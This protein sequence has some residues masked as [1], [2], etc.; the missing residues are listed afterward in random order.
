MKWY[1]L[2]APML[3]VATDA[4][5]RPVIN[6]LFRAGNLGATDEWMEIVLTEDMTAAELEAYFVGDSTAATDAKFSAYQF[7]AMAGIASEFRAGTII[8]IAG[9]TGGVADVAYDPYA[10]DWNILLTTGSPNLAVVTGGGD[11]AGTD[12]AWVDIASAGATL[13]A[14][15]F[16][17]NWDAT[18]GVFGAIASVTLAP[19][20]NNT[21]LQLVGATADATVPGNWA[22]S[23]APGSL[24][25]GLPNGG[26]NTIDIDALRAIDRDGD[27][28]GISEGDCDDDNDQLFPIAWYPDLDGDGV[29]EDDPRVIADS[30]AEFSANQGDSGWTYGSYPAFSPLLFTALPQFDNGAHHAAQSFSTPFVS[31]TSAHP[32]VDDFQWAV[33]RWTSDETATATVEL[34]AIDV[35]PFC[36]DGANVRL[37]RN[38]TEVW[39]AAVGVGG[40]VGPL[41]VPLDVGMGDTIDLIVDPIFDAGCDEVQLTAVLSTADTLLAC[42]DPGPGWSTTVGDCDDG[43]AGVFPGANEIGCNAID[44][45]CDPATLDV[46]D[47]DGDGSDV[48]DDCN[49][50]D[51]NVFPGASEIVADGIDQDCSGGDTCWADEDGDSHGGPDTVASMDADCDDPG[52]AAIDDDC[53][54]ADGAVSPDAIELCNDIDDDCDD[55]VDEGCGGTTTTDATTETTDATTET[56]DATTET[57]DATE[58]TSGSSE[59]GETT[60]DT[61]S[62]SESTGGSSEGESTSTS[63]DPDDTTGDPD[64]TGSGTTADT[65]GSTDDS[66]SGS[67]TTTPDTGDDTEDDASSDS[68]GDTD[69]AADDGGGCGC[70]SGGP[71]DRAWLVLLA[72]LALGRRR[73]R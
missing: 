63:G 59:G 58:S 5:A 26:A 31:A 44:D 60:G 55:E 10:G 24:T 66:V 54:D 68:S 45:D 48:C 47:D 61:G 36:N 73:R 11:F 22:V 13:D 56:T 9:A 6:E 2:T 64:T 57:T 49:D 65:S 33:R 53:N 7:T 3:I 72:P 32:G 70:T 16:A 1:W 34:E 43:Q 69:S 12:V 20:T 51:A 40:S 62:S 39:T 37:W 35:G 4:G 28:F 18:P 50:G 25:R 38:Q 27:G 42:G 41:T 23:V 30:V 29:A 71:D 17:V 52:E 14:D 15:S 21:G 19:P 67:P 46:F 8:V